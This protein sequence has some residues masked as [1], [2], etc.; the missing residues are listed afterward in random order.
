VNLEKLLGIKKPVTDLVAV[1]QRIL[2]DFEGKVVGVI[3]PQR[4][5]VDLL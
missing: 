3:S 2:L 1:K 5:V 4:G